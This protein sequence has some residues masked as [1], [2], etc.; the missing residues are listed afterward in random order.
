MENTSKQNNPL[1]R[2]VIAY[3]RRRQQNR[4]F[5]QIA[6][7]FAHEAERGK[8]TRKEMAEKLSKDPAQVSRWLSAPSNLTLDTISDI[9][10]SMGA[11][12][13]CTITRFVDRVQPNYA[14]PLVIDKGDSNQINTP[15]KVVIFKKPD[16]VLTPPF[17]STSVSP[18]AA[19]L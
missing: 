9:L 2:R 18:P 19:I 13:D 17:S 3:Y 6:Q 16:S 11:E 8:I 7:F 15:E 4:I 10:L 12:M 1:S 14:H 5:S